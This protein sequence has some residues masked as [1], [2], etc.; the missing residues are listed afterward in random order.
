MKKGLGKALTLGPGFPGSPFSPTPGIPL[1]EQKGKE[2]HS[3]YL[4]KILS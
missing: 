4:S 3:F 1:N 2:I